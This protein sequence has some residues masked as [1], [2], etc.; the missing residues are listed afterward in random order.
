V[1]R[2][3][4]AAA[5][6]ALA[7]GA[8]GGASSAG[9]TGGD[10][11]GAVATSSAGGRAA[12]G[13]TP[14]CQMRRR[15]KRVT[16]H[17]RRHGKLRTVHVTR[18]WWSCDPVPAAPA[19][20]TIAPSPSPAPAPVTPVDPG[21]APA[22]EPEP[23]LEPGP[24][25]LSVKAAEYSYTLSRPTLTAGEV[26]IELD[27]RGQD[28]HNLNLQKVGGEEAPLEIA[29]TQSLQRSRGH[30]TLEPG[31]YRLW[32]SLPTHDEEGMHATL[33]VEAP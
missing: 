29:E 10:S 5:V 28:A 1:R 17:L 23:E 3:A 2:A 25:R 21:P 11:S 6:I 14:G 19:P 22:P 9:A 30:F 24:S 7:L 4:L 20:T 12:G 26:T 32:C 31:V 8:L 15:S 16:R 33:V 27:N 18:H 13:A